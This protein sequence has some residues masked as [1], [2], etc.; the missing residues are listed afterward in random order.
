MP[1]KTHGQRSPQRHQEG[2]KASYQQLPPNPRSIPVE[3]QGFLCM[4]GE[5]AIECRKC[6]S[7]SERGYSPKTMAEILNPKL[8]VSGKTPQP[9]AEKPPVSR[10]M[11]EPVSQ[12][13]PKE[14]FSLPCA[15]SGVAKSEIPYGRIIRLSTQL[16]AAIVMLVWYWLNVTGGII[17]ETFLIPYAGPI[18]VPFPWLGF[19]GMCGLSLSWFVDTVIVWLAV[20]STLLLWAWNITMFLGIVGWQIN[21]LVRS[22]KDVTIKFRLRWRFIKIKVN[23]HVECFTCAVERLATLY[24]VPGECIAIAQKKML[25]VPRTIGGL[26]SIKHALLAELKTHCR[27]ASETQLMDVYLRSVSAIGVDAPAETALLAVY[28]TEG[29][30]KKTEEINRFTMSGLVNG[31]SLPTK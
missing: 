1:R 31:Y 25:M 24:K 23:S 13:G 8:E 20:N 11:P 30:Q 17:W 29:W 12:E 26:N 14:T 27:G 19:V 9:N 5:Y 2:G 28:A 3:F 10:V 16:L 21:H 6:H 18:Q 22:N 7:L 4:H 15:C